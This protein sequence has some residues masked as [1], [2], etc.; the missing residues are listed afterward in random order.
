MT[1]FSIM[2]DISSN[3]DSWKTCWIDS[4]TLQTLIVLDDLLGSQIISVGGYLSN[5]IFFGL[6]LN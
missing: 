2:S 6:N 4:L 5:Q 3:I 1:M